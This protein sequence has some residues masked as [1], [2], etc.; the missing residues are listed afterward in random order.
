MTNREEKTQKIAK[1]IIENA[2]GSLYTSMRYLDLA[3]FALTP[4]SDEN[5]D[6]CG[7]DGSRFFYNPAA[8]TDRYLRL[9]K[10]INRDLLHSIFHCLFRHLWSCK[11]YSE[12]D[13]IYWDIST[14]IAVEYL[15]DSLDVSAIPSIVSRYRTY[16]YKRLSLEME[17]L[18]AEGIFKSLKQWDISDSDFKIMYKS[19]QTDDHGYWQRPQGSEKTPPPQSNPNGDPENNPPEGI[20][21][22]AK[23]T[24]NNN[25][26]EDI[27]RRTAHQAEQ[28]NQTAGDGENDLVVSLKAANRRRHD[29]KSFLQRFAVYGEEAKP[30]PDSYDL[31]FYTYGMELY[32]N[33]PI[34]EPLEY[35][36]TKK[37]SDFI[38]VL[39]TSASCEGDAIQS[40]LN[41]T[42][43]I[44]KLRDSFF[45][46]TKIHIIQCDNKVR[47]DALIETSAD[48]EK[49]FGEMELKGFGGTD[50][51][52]AFEYV[53]E[54]RKNLTNLKGLIYF[55]DGEG[56]FPSSPPD[57][58]TAFV[59]LKEHYHDPKVPP[60]AI[61][62]ILDKEE[63]MK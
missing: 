31:A 37:V 43:S 53:E 14:D 58:D 55:T 60:W 45:N 8:L 40:F 1:M 44:L 54:I 15:I 19:F 39:D 23:E 21:N 41:Q 63:L 32:G 20:A 50:F 13:Q 57:Y 52:P 17:I 46:K 36:E 61:K 47:S 10:E 29:Y 4:E 59:F 25:K 2:R 11:K 35:K 27:S 34:I 5:I 9:P 16:I 33:M 6:P 28:L 48:L 26:W 62:L 49:Y 42:F 7:T 38:I 30:D 12:E 24:D 3:I 22:A 18:T 56:T 51:R